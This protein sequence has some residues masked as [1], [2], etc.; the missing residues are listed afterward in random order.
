MRALRIPTIVGCALLC[1]ITLSATSCADGLGLRRPAWKRSPPPAAETPVVRPGA[2]HRIEFDNGLV[3]LLLED[4]RLPRVALGLS[5]RRGAGD[6][7]GSQ[8]GLAALMAET[9]KRGAGERDALELAK[10]VDA[11]GAALSVSAGWDSVGITVDGLSRDTDRLFEV[12]AD[13][14]LRPRFDPDEVA[15]ARAEQLAGIAQATDDP[16]TLAS[17]HSAR[18]VYGTHRYGL[19]REGSP[20]T[21]E[22]L[23]V[24]AV[25][26]LNAAFFTPANAI[27]YAAGDLAPAD[28][29]RRAE[30]GFASWPRGEVPPLGQPPAA[31]APPA[32]SVVIVDRPDLVQ[33]RIAVSHEGLARSDERRIGASL[34]NDILGGSGFS[35]RLMAGLRA[36]HGLTYGVYSGFGLRRH[37]G[38][39]RAATF[40][41]VPETR[42]A[43]DLL[44]AGIEGMRENPPTAQELSD[45][46][47]LSI[48]RFGLGLETS[49]AVLS[50][51]VSLEIYGLP[52]DSLDTFRSRVRGVSMEDTARLSRDLLHPD[53]ASIVVVGPS[54]GLLP[55][56][57]GLG[58]VDVV[59]P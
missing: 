40:T 57:E 28:F 1:A 35:S 33:A 11:L 19:P 23:T 24:D 5:V 4:H 54:E 47:S 58:P 53:R 26:S 17:W 18:A 50:S 49:D 34:M 59:T 55:L 14:A 15:K 43:I 29:K 51:L 41:R 20:E 13:V 31:E 36:E 32:R 16:L 27:L 48:G 37:P 56:L 46:K 52:A 12:L 38:P 44:L 25:R 3:A 22:G 7:D 6:V 8:A 10:T 21:V 2:L 9:M 42:R 30:A 39:F 45:A